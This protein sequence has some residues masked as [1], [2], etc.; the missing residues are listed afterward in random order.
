MRSWIWWTAWRTLR[1]PA[2]SKLK[3]KVAKIDFGG[4]ML[5]VA[6]KSSAVNGF[7][8]VEQT[9]REVGLN[10]KLVEVL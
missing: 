6:S 3:S 8:L 1:G 7:I 2:E 9:E 4:F 5:I 10:C